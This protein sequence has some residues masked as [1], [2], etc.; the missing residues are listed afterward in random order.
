MSVEHSQPPPGKEIKEK[1]EQEAPFK[2]IVLGH[3][4]E[5]IDTDQMIAKK[6][7]EMLGFFPHSAEIPIE[8]VPHVSNEQLNDKSVFVVEGFDSS[9]EGTNNLETGNF[10]NGPNDEPAA[11]MVLRSILKDN[12]TSSEAFKQDINRELGR[13]IKDKNERQKLL[14]LVGWLSEGE[15]KGKTT[16]SLKDWNYPRVLQNTDLAVFSKVFNGIKEQILNDEKKEKEKRLF[17]AVDD[18]FQRLFKAEGN[19]NEI[20]KDEIAELKRAQEENNEKLEKH[21]L[22]YDSDE[23]EIGLNKKHLRTAKL[24]TNIHVT[25]ADIRG[26]GIHHGGPGEAVDAVRRHSKSLQYPKGVDTDILVFANDEFG[27]DRKP[28]G[29]KKVM[30]KIPKEKSGTV[31]VNLQELAKRLNLSEKLFGGGEQLTSI[32][33]YGGHDEVIVSP[34]F[35]GT[36]LDPDNLYVG[37]QNYFSEKRFTEEEFLERAKQFAQKLGV[38]NYTTKIAVPRNEYEIAQR[39]F[40]IPRSGGGTVEIYEDELSLY[41]SAFT[42][43]A[44][45]NLRIVEQKTEKSEALE[46]KNKRAKMAREKLRE[47]L[48]EGN[49]TQILDALAYIPAQEISKLDEQT[50]F[51]IYDLIANDEV[52]ISNVWNADDGRFG[53]EGENVPDWMLNTPDAYKKGRYDFLSTVQ[54]KVDRIISD[55]LFRYVATKEHTEMHSKFALDLAK[56]LTSS[57]YKNSH[58]NESYD[59]HL[60]MML[61]YIGVKN[62]K[63]KTARQMLSRLFS[64]SYGDEIKKHWQQIAQES[65]D[66]L[67]NA[68]DEFPHEFE[69][70]IDTLQFDVSEHRIEGVKNSSKV[71]PDPEKIRERI[72]EQK[73]LGIN[74][75]RLTVLMEIGRPIQSQLLASE[76]RTMGRDGK[77]RGEMVGVFDGVMKVNGFIASRSEEKAIV[78]ELIKQLAK[79]EETVN[80]LEKKDKPEIRIVFGSFPNTLM[81]AVAKALSN[82]DTGEKRVDLGREFR[83]RL[84]TCQYDQLK[85]EFNDDYFVDEE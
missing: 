55:K 31:N 7:A 61:Q 44:D 32:A 19:L 26:L 18:L 33:T 48:V 85:H 80:Q 10:H 77:I 15:T 83:E 37:L 1:K 69:E 9:R 52:A 66:L 12:S 34:Q 72:E 16:G 71:E 56:I 45:S 65:P 46:I 47:S 57:A 8:C 60:Q 24:P 79:I 35:E 43:S 29:R 76:I 81:L 21:F 49:A 25:F 54:A 30:I 75:P 17:A 63:S 2:N 84:I 50:L 58:K 11:F 68:I 41:E 23:N 59:R 36:E 42:K 13:R 64:T 14:H 27:P 6:V 40:V 78:K 4:I 5:E 3:P 51:E 70:I 53:I 62:E 74:P 38:A 20:Y 28:N 67:L 82:P 22:I 73:K 39:A